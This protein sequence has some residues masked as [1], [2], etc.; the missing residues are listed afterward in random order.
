MRSVLEGFRHALVKYDDKLWKDYKSLEEDGIVEAMEGRFSRDRIED[1]LLKASSDREILLE[2]ME[3]NSKLIDM[4][5]EIE[6]A[7][8]YG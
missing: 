8:R 1:E 6:D 5:N 4:I 2:V 3:A 7:E